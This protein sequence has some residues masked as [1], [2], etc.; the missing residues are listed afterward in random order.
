MPSDL[1]FYIKMLQQQYSIMYSHTWCLHVSLYISMFL[2]VL[3]CTA[4][5]CATEHVP[6]KQVRVV[7]VVSMQS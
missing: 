3:H 1:I 6:A 5:T 2:A 7:Q 4:G